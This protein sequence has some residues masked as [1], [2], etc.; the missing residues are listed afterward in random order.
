ME[1]DKKYSAKEAALAV[2]KKAEEVIQKSELMKSKPFEKFKNDK[3]HSSKS[4]KAGVSGQSAQGS[5]VRYGGGMAMDA[6]VGEAK[7]RLA[8]QR[9]MPK[10]K[11]D[12]SEALGKAEQDVT[13]PDAVQ[14]QPAPAENYNGNPAP[15][16]E[17]QNLGETYKGHI[18]LAKFIGRVEAK[19]GAKQAAPAAP[20][21]P[22][23]A[24]AGK[25][26]PKV[27]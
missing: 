1:H 26:D 2:L 4:N 11:L 22:A 23:A 14:K 6:A 8:N 9:A 17:P 10:P 16:A 7:H 5:H 24:P 12:K 25:P 21:A 15:G 18:K 19:R 3:I 20:E 13:P 27:G